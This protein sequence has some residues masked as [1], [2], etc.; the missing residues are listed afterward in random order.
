MAGELYYASHIYNPLFYA[1]TAR[2]AEELISQGAPDTIIL[3]VGN[4]TLL[5]GLYHGFKRRGSVPRLIA[6]QL[7]GM[8][9]IT[10]EFRRRTAAGQATA[11]PRP[12]MRTGTTSAFGHRSGGASSVDP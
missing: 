3:P 10:Q 8:D 5:L 1:G 7:V 6:G 9:P 4:G 12:P 11:D 2:L